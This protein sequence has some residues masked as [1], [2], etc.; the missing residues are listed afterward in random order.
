MSPNADRLIGMMVGGWRIYQLMP[1]CMIWVCFCKVESKVFCHLPIVV[2][3]WRQEV[4]KKW[5]KFK[6]VIV[7]TRKEC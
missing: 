2:G 5:A 3:K 7:K 4:C 6:R 1:F